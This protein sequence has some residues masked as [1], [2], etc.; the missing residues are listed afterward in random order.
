MT[1]FP[2]QTE[3]F[4]RAKK[5]GEEQ[6]TLWCQLDTSL[7]RFGPE[8]KEAVDVA[9]L[10]TS[11]WPFL[12]GKVNKKF[13]VS[14]QRRERPQNNG[15][16][17]ASSVVAR[18]DHRLGAIQPAD[19]YI[20]LIDETGK[21]FGGTSGPEGRFVAIIAPEGVL[22]EFK[23]HATDATPEECDS[24]M[25]DLLDKNTAVL[26][27]RLSD[28]PQLDGDRWY[29]GVL[30]LLFWIARVIPLTSSQGPVNIE[31]VVEQ[32]GRAEAGD[33]WPEAARAITRSL[34]AVDAERAGR[35]NIKGTSGNPKDTS[36]KTLFYFNY[37]INCWA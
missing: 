33:R 37:S 23:I 26:G 17:R 8:S 18:G 36:V 27:I 7:V 25:Q 14:R 12:G 13:D 35:L 20:V 2:S 3:E 31:V 9:G 4:R 10:L 21:D 28:L 16:L 29:D 30:E 19:T 11:R 32:R 34:L 1:R 5:E 15:H 22:R 24:V 6:F